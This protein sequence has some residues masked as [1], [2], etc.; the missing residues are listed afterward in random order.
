M[1]IFLIALVVVILLLVVY[2]KI[3]Y[4]RLRNEFKDYLKK[5]SSYSTA[6]S[7][8]KLSDLPEC[9]QKFYKLS[10]LDKKTGADHVSFTFKNTDFMMDIDSKKMIKIDYDEHIYGGKISR[11]AF[12]DSAMY[13]IPFQGLDSFYDGKGGMKGVVAKNITIFNQRGRKM[14]KA[15]L[16]TWLAE[17]IFMPSQY[18]NGTVHFEEI[19]KNTVNVSV[20]YDDISVSGV[21]KF[22]DDGKVL[23][24]TTDDRGITKSDGTLENRRWS[25]IFDDY[26]DKDGMYLP[27]ALK[28][29]WHYDTYEVVYFD[30]HNFKYTFN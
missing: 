6:S 16:V 26:K 27:D 20:K 9:M 13:G 3:P 11:F 23:R 24:F 22:D 17:T 29:A 25:A 7:T 2:F 12:I 15:A 30:G 5:S 10:G 18:L 21:Y 14:D 1:K 4:S 28:S 8:K 19:D